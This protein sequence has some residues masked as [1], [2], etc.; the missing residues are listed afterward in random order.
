MKKWQ[1]SIATGRTMWSI[2]RSICGSFRSP[3]VRE[4]HFRIV[5]SL[6]VGLV[7]RL[8]VFLLWPRL[9]RTNRHQ[10]AFVSATFGVGTILC[11]SL[12]S[13]LLQQERLAAL[14][15]LLFDR[16]VPEDRVTL[17]IIRA[18]V[19]NFSAAR[20]LH[21]EFAPTARPWAL[22]AGGFLLDVLAFRIV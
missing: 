13:S 9:W 14:R 6:T 7:T 1:V 4:G 11:R 20:F 19:E 16:L 21:H 17:R 5:P 8:R 15:T 10:L 2:Q 18:A 22:H 12:L 3:T